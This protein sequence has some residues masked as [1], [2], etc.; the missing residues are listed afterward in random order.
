MPDQNKVAFNL[1]QDKSAE[2]KLQARENIDAVG[3][4]VQTGDGPFAA[5]HSMQACI[6]M[7]SASGTVSFDGGTTTPLSMVKMP[8]QT[9]DG[10]I[11]R[12]HH[13]NGQTFFTWD[14]ID[15]TSGK[16]VVY[17]IANGA[18]SSTGLYNAM[19]SVI[20]SGRIPL[21]K[22]EESTNPSQYGY[23]TLIYNGSNTLV[24]ARWTGAAL[25]GLS[26]SNSD[27]I[28]I[29]SYP[30]IDIHDIAPEVSSNETY[31]AN[32][33][34]IHDNKLYRAKTAVPSVGWDVG[35]W[36]ETNMA[37]ELGR[38]RNAE[39]EAVAYNP[40]HPYRWKVPNNA[41]CSISYEETS[42]TPDIQ[43]EV[44]IDKDE[45]PNFVVEM[46]APNGG[47]VDVL[48]HRYEPGNPNIAPITTSAFYSRTAG[49]TLPVARKVQ[50]TCVG[51]C[52]TWEE[53]LDPSL[54]RSAEEPQGESEPS[55]APLEKSSEIQVEPVESSEPADVPVKEQLESLEDSDKDEQEDSGDDIQPT[56]K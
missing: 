11:L 2:E 13:V 15:L 26:V 20:S 12:A 8:V 38:V 24:F 48:I 45:V 55:D 22:Y 33:L 23:Y 42:S 49:N 18:T 21:V 35:Y 6:P 51:N 47:V 17:N 32:T 34:R 5:V 46:S 50:I 41:W 36:H 52:W 29:S 40:S 14:S 9:D 25:S 7:A 56:R 28:T 37:H 53:Y 39:N 3:L 16:V 4:S 10:K 43:I 27:A 1:P 44:D 19:V 30:V 54:S 31:S